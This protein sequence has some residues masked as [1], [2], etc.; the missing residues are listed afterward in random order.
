LKN[1]VSSK[2]AVAIN[3][4]YSE[5]GATAY[6]LSVIGET[7]KE[8]GINL[9]V[10]H[11]GQADIRGCIACRRC[12][13]EARGCVHATEDERRWIDEMKRANAVIL[14]AP[15]CFG[16]IPGTMKSF[17]DKAFFANSKHFRYKIGAAV[18]TTPRTGASMTFES[19][20]QYFTISEMTVASSTYWN[21]VRG[22]TL[23]DLQQD[24]EG[25]NTMKNLAKN[26]VRL[27]R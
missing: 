22:L 27:I 20:N 7:L 2:K 25:I 4:D 8:A 6:A 5:T 18:V 11:I 21:N 13:K 14:A 26:M 19:L 9:E 3:G 15:T 24:I 16:G 1:A 10:I 12:R 17:L 23:N